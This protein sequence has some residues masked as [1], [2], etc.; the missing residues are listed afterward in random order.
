MVFSTVLP[1]ASDTET[2]M[3]CLPFWSVRRT[4]AS[5]SELSDWIGSPSILMVVACALMPE[6]FF[7]STSWYFAT[8][9][10]ELEAMTVSPS[11][12]SVWPL[13]VMSLMTGLSRSSRFV[14]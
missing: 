3:V 4:V 12:V 5:A 14:P 2:V 10:M 9:S 8:A 1:N 6:Q 7:P 13:T 11:L